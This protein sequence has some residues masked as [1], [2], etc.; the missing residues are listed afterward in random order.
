MA[1]W[2]TI[3]EFPEFEVSD[4]GK[5]RQKTTMIELRQRKAF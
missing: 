3:D 1:N 4:E 2:L 5:V